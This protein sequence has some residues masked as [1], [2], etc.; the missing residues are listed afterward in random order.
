MN[1]PSGEACEVSMQLRS[2]ETDRVSFYVG[3]GS[4][5]LSRDM[6]SLQP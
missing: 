1:K 3:R 5:S 6:G 2:A 4:A